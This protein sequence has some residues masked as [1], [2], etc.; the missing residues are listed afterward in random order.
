[1]FVT[2]TSFRGTFKSFWDLTEA[3]EQSW[4]KVLTYELV[5]RL[6]KSNLFTGLFVPPKM[7]EPSR[8]LVFDPYVPLLF[9]LYH[10]LVPKH[11]PGSSSQVLADGRVRHPLGSRRV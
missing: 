1:M 11:A 10:Q 7:K 3:S 9:D 2:S 8:V 5:H 6:S 4:Y